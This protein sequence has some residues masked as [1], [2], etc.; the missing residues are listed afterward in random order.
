MALKTGAEIVQGL[1]YK[2]RMMGIT[3]DGPAQMRVDNM[4]VVN[5]TT[6]PESVLWK[7]SNSIAYHFVRE[8]VAAGWIKI[9][10][11]NTKTNLADMLT[12]VQ[13]GPERRRLADMVLF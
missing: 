12:K 1:R 4:S 6:S 2:L 10:Y 7:K 5:N 3:L 9:G 11:E 8:S 13:T